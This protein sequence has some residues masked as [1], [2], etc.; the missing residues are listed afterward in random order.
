MQRHERQ[1]EVL[2]RNSDV[3]NEVHQRQFCFKSLPLIAA[4]GMP[5]VVVTAIMLVIGDPRVGLVSQSI[6]G[7]LFA[8][9]P[10]PVLAI[11]A[12][13]HW[14]SMSSLKV[15]SANAVC[16]NEGDK[17]MIQAKLVSNPPASAYT[18]SWSTG[19]GRQRW[20]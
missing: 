7:V 19:T 20:L 10:V 15:D 14:S 3:L 6:G 2:H 16:G 13:H 1:M 12:Y 9:I 8:A 18:D 11:A 17:A 5:L 4:A